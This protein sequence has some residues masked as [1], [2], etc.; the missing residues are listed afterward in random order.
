VV[1]FR[2]DNLLEADVEA[3]VNTVNTV[4]VMGKGIALQFKKKFPENFKA[5]EQAHKNGELRI[6][7]MFTV[8]L[9]LTN[10][11]Y[12]INFPT[13]NHWREKS[14]V[15]YVREGL[16]DLLREIERLDIRSVA[17][18][19]LGC[20]NGGLDW[21]TEVRPLIEGAFARVPEVQ[22]YAYEPFAASDPVVMST[23]GPRPDLTPARAVMLWLIGAYKAS[24]YA[25][26]RLAAQKL[27]YFAQTAGEASLN[28][29]FEEAKYG[30]YAEKLN[31]L[32]QALEGH[33]TRGYGDR[34]SKSD[35]ELLPGS[36]EEAA[37]FLRD[38]PEIEARLEKVARLI[39]GFETP[40]GM[41]LLATVH[42]VANRKGATSFDDA[43]RIVQEWNPRK[44]HLFSEQHVGVAWER[45]EDEGWIST[46][47]AVPAGS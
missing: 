35:I 41:E 36:E 3:L 20:G 44:E 42:W 45:L 23:E 12:I 43:L 39:E 33:Y 17:L 25:L 18:P 29:D 30:P 38:H 7:K 47:A 27:A 8:S 11:R 28:L 46:T 19:P 14:R 32:L 9:Q 5:Y 40:Y 22:V 16:E 31:F 15:E 13:K 34:S 10:P 24:H 2:S 4:G 21:E 6:G 26:G 1:E 37:D